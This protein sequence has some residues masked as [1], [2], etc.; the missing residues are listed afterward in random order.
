VAWTPRR[1]RLG[2]VYHG[3]AVNDLLA[4]LAAPPARRG[5]LRKRRAARRGAALRALDMQVQMGYAEDS[6]VS[7]RQGLG[8][9]GLGGRRSSSPSPASRVSPA[10]V[11]R[12]GSW[13]LLCGGVGAKI[14]FGLPIHWFRK[15]WG[16]KKPMR[17]SRQVHWQHIRARALFV[18]S[19]PGTSG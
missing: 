10:G 8:T 16:G 1:H 15:D 2:G 17:L 7:G 5:G 12:E 11:S 4:A 19:L 6:G 13:G 14:A 9:A 3:V 18:S